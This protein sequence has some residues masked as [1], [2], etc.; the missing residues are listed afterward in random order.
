MCNVRDN[1]DQPR[2]FP[3]EHTDDQHDEL[4][5]AHRQL[6][7]EFWA[8]CKAPFNPAEHRRYLAKLAEHLRALRLHHEALRRRP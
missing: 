6:V 3:R 7:Q 4:A 2:R 1:A 8:L 5:E